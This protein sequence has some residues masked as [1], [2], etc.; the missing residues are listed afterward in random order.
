MVWKRTLLLMATTSTTLALMV[1]LVAAQQ[2]PPSPA[3]VALSLDPGTTALLVLDVTTQ[4]CSPQPNCLEMVPRIAALLAT[5]RAAGVY[6]VYSTPATQPPI[7]PEVAPANGDPV[8]P[9][10]GQDRFFDTALD[11]FVESGFLAVQEPLHQSF[12]S[13]R[14]SMTHLRWGTGNSHRTG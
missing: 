14:A 8:V 13:H 9:G 7:L 10:L 3:P 5:A 6:V 12:V 11:E 1:G 4:T 2:V